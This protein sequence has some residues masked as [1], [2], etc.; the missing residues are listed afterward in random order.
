M[1]RR[2]ASLS[3]AYAQFLRQTREIFKK[4]PARL[5]QQ[6]GTI[7]DKQ[8]EEEIFALRVN[9]L[10]VLNSTDTLFPSA[11]ENRLSEMLQRQWGLHEQRG[12][13]FAQ[14]DRLDALM[15]DAIARQHSRRHRIYGSLFSALGMGI[16]ASHVWEPVRDILTTNE[17]E[18]QLM[19]FKHPETTTQQLAE[20]AG[21]SAHFELISLIVFLA[22]G[23]LGF[24]LFWF[25]DIRSQEE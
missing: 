8:W 24:I 13:L 17:Y 22:F 21:Q 2:I 20:I 6:A 9:A 3:D 18:W 1:A 12:N 7:E 14:V 16:G 4:W 23:L 19:L 25:F 5:N 15:R 10:N 11:Q